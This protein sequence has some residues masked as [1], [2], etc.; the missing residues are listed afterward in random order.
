MTTSRQTIR[1]KTA[2]YFPKTVRAIGAVFGLFGLA[3][4]LTS[5]VLG[6]LFVF[7]TLVIFTTHYG[8]EIAVQPNSVREYIS[9]LG[10]KDGKRSPFNAIEFI[11]IQPGKLRF[12]TYSL[13]EK[14]SDCTEAYL[15]FEGR[16]EM[17]MLALVKKENLVNIMKGIASR[18]KVEIRDYSEGNP[19]VIYEPN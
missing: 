4:V 12:L 18:L 14:E 17:M 1:F 7:I 2:Y 8:F 16:N 19:V 3:M 5:P 13:R 9:V 6:L 11:F 10:F 15:K